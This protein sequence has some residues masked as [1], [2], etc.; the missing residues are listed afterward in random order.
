[1]LNTWFMQ[2]NP[3]G[4]QQGGG[5]GGGGP[6]IQGATGPRGYTGAKGATGIAGQ[7]GATGLQGIDGLPGV[8]G[9]GGLPGN[10]GLPGA[11]GVD[12]LPGLD[13]QPG[14]T[15]ADGPPGND[16]RQ[17]DTGAD[18]LQGATGLPGADGFTGLPGAVGA[19]GASGGGA[20]GVKGATGLAG[21]TGLA[22]AAGA[23]GAPGG[24]TGIQGATGVA[25]FTGL[26]GVTGA[27]G[28]GTGPQGATGVGIVGATGV[29]GVTGP[30]GPGGGGTG[31]GATGPVGPQG[32]T[33]PSG[34]GGT[35]DGATGP[36]GMDGDGIVW[37]QAALLG[38]ASNTTGYF[39]MQPGNA[40]P[41]GVPID[42]SAN[43]YG[44]GSVNGIKIPFDY[45]LKEIYMSLAHCA[46]A[47]ATVSDPVYLN[48][49]CHTFL[50]SSDALL[51]S[52]R[53]P[54]DGTKCGI[55]NNLGADSF[56]KASVSGIS[57]ISG[58]AGDLFG[59][60][61]RNVVATTDVNA[62]SR[63][64]VLVKLQRTNWTPGG[65]KGETGVQGTRGDTGAVGATGPLGGPPGATGVSGV[66]GLA[67]IAGATGIS[68]GGTGL[69]GPTGA[70]GVDGDGIVWMNAAMLGTAAST[71]GYFS[72][73]PG[74]SNPFGIPIDT[75]TSTYGSGSVNGI[76]I[77]FDY[78]LKELYLSV[79]HCAVSTATASNP[80]YLSLDFHTFLGSSSALLGTVKVPLDGTNCGVFNNLGS[81]NFQKAVVSGVTGIS[82]TAGDLVGF[83]FRNVGGTSTDINA[84]SRCT[85]L[86]KWQRQNWTP[87]GMKGE[88]GL[89]GPQGLTGVQGVTGVQSVPGDTVMWAQAT[90][91][92]TASSTYGLYSVQPGIG[93]PFGAPVSSPYDTYGN[94]GV[95]AFKLPWPYVVSEVHLAAAHL[96]V[97]SGTANPVVN[98]NIDFDRYKGASSAS[99]GSVSIPLDGSNCGTYNNLGADNF[100]AVSVSGLGLTGPATELV[101]FRFR[102]VAGASDVNAVSR[103]TVLVKF[104]KQGT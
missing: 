13:G 20:T 27:S 40:N 65:T 44:N 29:M 9:L 36:R 37:V 6:G 50:G 59:F 7:A 16:G 79:A 83:R 42:T 31:S 51:G 14:F 66:T 19:T 12:G 49:D 72:V 28:G 25:G 102:N 81:D 26:R 60:R 95:N 10:D 97:S 41:F 32:V 68:G 62:I 52:I 87:G 47:T 11:T 93:N 89:L 53:V 2:S 33:G 100:Q 18:G 85:V 86:A 94:G 17:G 8:T 80:A 24:G 58:T 48:L 38:T 99:V 90:L 98:F 75:S 22:G 45:E 96:A 64:T 5:T 57:G 21:P 70:R 35:G 77:P 76:K 56:Q 101:G 4:S 39:S 88:T 104:R 69:Q 82:G 92:G 30:A 23:T 103:S 67:G 15:G 63:C 84:V 1:M 54:L 73:Q 71:I 61:F 78:E 34:G 43:T 91:L 3:G 55:Y 46:V 74:N